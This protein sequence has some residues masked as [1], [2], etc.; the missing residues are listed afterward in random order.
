M[1][2]K[3]L[4]ELEIEYK[5]KKSRDK[6]FKKTKHDWFMIRLICY[7]MMSVCILF[8][9]ISVGGFINWIFNII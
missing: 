8:V 4:K 7:I 6:L 3:Y 2:D 5:L 9:I 1:E